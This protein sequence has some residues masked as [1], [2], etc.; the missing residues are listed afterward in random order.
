MAVF[1]R[2]NGSAETVVSVGAVS[3]SAETSSTP[4]MVGV[5]PSPIEFRTL[6][7]NATMAA[8]MGTGEA[9]EAL[10]KWLGTTSTIL[11]YQVDTTTLSVMTQAADTTSWTAANANTALDGDSIIN[12]RVQSVNDT[13]FKLA[14]S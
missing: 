2:T 11:G 6:V 12:I 13:G 7:A 3:V 1:T 10:L 9:V 14:T 8:E 5:G 4:I